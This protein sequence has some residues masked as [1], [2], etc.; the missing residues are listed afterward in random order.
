M[1][2]DARKCKFHASLAASELDIVLLN[3][4]ALVSAVFFFTQIVA[5][6]S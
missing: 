1:R 3:Y 5:M 2:A 6:K 4:I